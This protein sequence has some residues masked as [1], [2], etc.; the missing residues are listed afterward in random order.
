MIETGSGPNYT[1]DKQQENTQE[2]ATI[3][4]K[5]YEYQKILKHIKTIR[6][7]KE[8]L[9]SDLIVLSDTLIELSKIES[10]DEETKTI[11]T[12]SKEDITNQTKAKRE[13]LHQINSEENW[14]K[15]TSDFLRIS[16]SE[17]AF[18]NLESPLPGLDEAYNVLIKS[19]NELE[20]ELHEIESELEKEKQEFE[21]EINKSIKVQE[22]LITKEGSEIGNN[23]EKILVLQNIIQTLK[24]VEKLLT[25]KWSEDANTQIQRLK[26]LNTISLKSIKNINE[27]ITSLKND[28]KIFPEHINTIEIKRDSKN[29]EITWIQVQIDKN[30]ASYAEEQTN[31]A[32]QQQKQ[33]Q[34]KKQN[35]ENE[36]LNNMMKK[37]LEDSE[38]W[39]ENL[40]N[41][42][43]SLALQESAKDLEPDTID[44]VDQY[45]IK[46]IARYTEVILAYPQV[47]TLPEK[48]DF[49]TRISTIWSLSRATTQD[50]KRFL[51]DTSPYIFETIKTLEDKD[52]DNYVDFLNEKERKE[53]IEK[54]SEI[55]K[56]VLKIEEKVVFTDKTNHTLTDI[57]LNEEKIGK[58]KDF[59]IFWKDKINLDTD[60]YTNYWLISEFLKKKLWYKDSEMNPCTNPEI[61]ITFANLLAQ[62]KYPQDSVNERALRAMKIAKAIDLIWKIALTH[63]TSRETPYIPKR[64]DDVYGS[65]SV[66]AR[67]I[68]EIKNTNENESGVDVCI[69]QAKKFDPEIFDLVKELYNIK[70]KESL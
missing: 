29:S 69:K 32:E 37:D 56:T 44:S 67:T 8:K 52:D 28:L 55:Y 59:Y 25:T 19:K 54:L 45:D 3:V 31:L 41:Y 51:F 58:V 23:E 35:E 16:I 48:N 40:K 11:I 24:P 62:L 6:E 65:S 2:N 70:E 66:I 57:E 1:P 27:K 17:E 30:R 15:M 42:T 33:E 63:E 46:N 26:E 20:S 61:K 43:L 47:K 12:E 38:K 49:K 68:D 13:V 5:Q 21:W 39:S 60:I 14:E 50:L 9:N 64:G 4:Q 7:K 10:T 36:Y 34:I 18:I 22:D 53:A